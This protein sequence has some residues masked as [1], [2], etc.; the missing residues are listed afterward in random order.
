MN[1]NDLIQQLERYKA[2][3]TEEDEMRKR[4][5]RFVSQNENCFDRSLLI[6]HCT[7][8][9]WVVNQNHSKVL[10]IHHAKLQKWLQPGG[11]CDGSS[12]VYEVALKELQEETGLSPV[13][14]LKTIFDVDIHTIPERKGIPQH[15]HFDIRYL[16]EIDDNQS[17]VQNHETNAIQ[18]IDIDKID[19]L[20]SERSVI[21]MAQKITQ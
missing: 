13:K 21:R 20:T 17:I 7:G 1:R 18:W 9:A 5:V 8:S 4:M 11:H 12:N 16:F 19:Q 3:D 15:E 14:H 2:Y 10:L 6:G